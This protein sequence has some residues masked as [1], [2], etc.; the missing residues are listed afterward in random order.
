MQTNVGGDSQYFA[1]RQVTAD[2]YRDYRIPAWLTECLPADRSAPILDIGC[3]L[4]HVLKALRERGHDNLTGIDISS[5]AAEHCRVEGLPVEE[6]GDLREY[7]RIAQRRYDFILMSH[8]LEHIEKNQIIPTLA[9]IRSF[10]LSEKGSLC[11]QVPN[12]QS[13]TGCYWAYEDF[14]HTTLFT[15]GSLLYVLKAAGFGN[16]TFLDPYHLSD[17]VVVKRVI[18]RC[19]LWLYTANRH[20]WNRV[21]CSGY[22]RAS[23]E[24]F[25][26]ELRA[27]ARL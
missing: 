12:A 7:C 27:L 20:F 9:D 24:C 4:G 17:T 6:I 11:L 15:G 18:K 3:G 8:V 5:Q 2:D 13:N 22:H 21:T 19:L 25:A 23:P 16:V 1:W 10:L 26:Y 14:T